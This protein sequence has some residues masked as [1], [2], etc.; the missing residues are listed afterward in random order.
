MHVVLSISNPAL[1]IVT[2]QYLKRYLSKGEQASDWEAELSQA[3]IECSGPSLA[4]HTSVLTMSRRIKGR[5]GKL[6]RL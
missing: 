5:S 2:L 3:Q 1:T 4:H 6:P